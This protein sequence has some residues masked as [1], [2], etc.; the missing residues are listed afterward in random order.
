MMKYAT[1]SGEFF[2]PH[3]RVKMGGAVGTLLRWLLLLIGVLLH[4]LGFALP[5][6]LIIFSYLVFVGG[7][8]SIGVRPAGFFCF[9][10]HRNAPFYVKV[11]E[12]TF[13][14]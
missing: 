8:P 11:N 7:S 12:F 3:F 2:S 13:S 14:Y 10:V 9:F 5:V 4:L 6:T 1:L